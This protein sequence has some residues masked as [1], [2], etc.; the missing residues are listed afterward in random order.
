MA[1]WNPSKNDKV[2]WLDASDEAS[3]TLVNGEISQVDD[4]SGNARHATATTRP[5]YTAAGI[6]GLNVIDT[7][8]DGYMLALFGSTLDFPP[9]T[10][11]AVF[12]SDTSGGIR[13]LFDMRLGSDDRPLLDDGSDG[14]FGARTRNTN[15]VL[16]SAAS[17][18]RDTS[19]HI[20]VYR[21]TDST[22]S[23]RLDGGAEN[24]N[25]RSGHVPLDRVGICCNGYNPPINRFPGFLGEFLIFPSDLSDGEVDT[26]EGYA[27]HK[28]GLAGNLPSDHPYKA[29]PPGS[30]SFLLRH[31]P[32]TNK[33]IPVLSS[34]T[35]TDIGA[36]C[37]RPR[38]TKG[39]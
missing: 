7:S 18:T 26:V 29:A 24:T 20:A 32:R 27:A 2:L 33:V 10:I 8:A 21:L 9:A 16:R 30:V 28:W 34:P 14:G 38:V 25:S 19:P 17:H 37:V 11:V 31:N 4:K 12:K 23:V 1:L 13:Q 5:V 6:G 22:I 39:Y 3:V 15:S 35:V 36:N